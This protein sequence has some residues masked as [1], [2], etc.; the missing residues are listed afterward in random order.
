MSASL[1]PEAIW[2]GMFSRIE[3]DCGELLSAT[4]W[5]SQT[6]HASWCSSRAAR[7]A[8]ELSGRVRTTRTTMPT[9]TIR[10]SAS[11]GSSFRDVMSGLFRRALLTVP[12]RLHPD[13]EHLLG[14]AAERPADRD[15]VG[16]DHVRLRL[17]GRPVRECGRPLRI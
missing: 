8:G 4:D 16:C 7:A 15:T 13:V 14:R 6:G 10:P 9:T 3:R 1:I 12:G 11:Q 2:R 5:P 17:T